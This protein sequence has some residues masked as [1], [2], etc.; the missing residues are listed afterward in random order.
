MKKE[1]FNLNQQHLF[2]ASFSLM[3]SKP[4]APSGRQK[5]KKE[6]VEAQQTSYQIHHPTSNTYQELNVV[7]ELGSGSFGSVYKVEDS[8]GHVFALKKISCGN[9]NVNDH[10]TKVKQNLIGAEIYSM[11][12]LKHE[13]IVQ[14][15]SFDFHGINAL[16]VIEYCPNGNLNERLTK[17]VNVKQKFTWMCQLLEA[18]SYLHDQNIVHRDL[19]PENILLGRKNEMKLADFGISKVF[20]CRDLRSNEDYLLE[21]E[22]RFMSKYAGTMYWVAPEVFDEMYT[23][24]ADIFSLGVIFYAILTRKCLTYQ[25]TSYFGAFVDYQGKEVGIGMAMQRSRTE[26]TP[27]FKDVKDASEIEAV[28]VVKQMMCYKYE[29]R[30]TLSNAQLKIGDIFVKFQERNVNK[31]KDPVS[32]QSVHSVVDDDDEINRD[33]NKKNKKSLCEMFCP[34]KGFRSI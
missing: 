3:A 18:M 11:L 7:S 8:R 19:K 33:H 27:S 14:L 6:K 4:S 13:Y 23:Q 32:V 22:D 26:F 30:I 24:M 34:P 17:S 12:Q 20:L 25:G 5:Q 21:Y 2:V 1:K 15:Y 9:H 10:R 16:L 29:E 28:S 31:T